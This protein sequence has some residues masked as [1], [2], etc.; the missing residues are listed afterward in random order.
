[1]A[2]RGADRD[3]SPCQNTSPPPSITRCAA[4]STARGPFPQ[5]LHEIQAK[6]ANYHVVS[7]LISAREDGAR[8]MQLTR[9]FLYASYSGRWRPAWR[10]SLL[11][12]PNSRADE[13]S[14]VCEQ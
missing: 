2:P 10:K 9:C 14:S 6:H 4:L 13:E 8:Y 7:D 12:A 1:M 11:R 5:R 3:K